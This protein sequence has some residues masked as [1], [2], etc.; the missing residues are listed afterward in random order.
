MVDDKPPQPVIIVGAAEAGDTA[1][2]MV[3]AAGEITDSNGAA[4][5]IQTGAVSTALQDGLW[6]PNL[7]IA[8]AAGNRVPYAVGALWRPF[9]PITQLADGAGNPGAD[10]EL[11]PFNLNDFIDVIVWFK[12]DTVSGAAEQIMRFRTTTAVPVPVDP[13]WAAIVVPLAALEA[14]P[15]STYGFRMI[16]TV[17]SKNFGISAGQNGDWP[18]NSSTT[19]WGFYRYI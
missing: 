6:A 14:M 19:F 8:S 12:S 3:N 5:L 1:P 15:P 2:V 7:L 13:P 4:I 11:C 17:V 18:I 16:T 10:N 9:G